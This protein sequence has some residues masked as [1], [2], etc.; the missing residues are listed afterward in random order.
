MRRAAQSLLRYSSLLAHQQAASTSTVQVGCTQAARTGSWGCG[1]GRRQHRAGHRGLPDPL[2]G[3]PSL[4]HFAALQATACAASSRWFATNSHDIFNVVSAL[5][6]IG[7]A[8][9]PWQRN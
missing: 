4:L 7:L 2:S 3:R 8:T 9:V 1:G 6:G 5:P